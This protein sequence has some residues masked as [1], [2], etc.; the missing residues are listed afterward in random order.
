VLEKI[1]GDLELPDQVFGSQVRNLTLN[2]VNLINFSS[3]PFVG[4][5]EASDVI[6]DNSKITATK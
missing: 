2:E 5:T 6:I 1:V 4:L 3:Q